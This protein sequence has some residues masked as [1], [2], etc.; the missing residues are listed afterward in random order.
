[1][2]ASTTIDECRRLA[3][4]ALASPTAEDARAVVRQG[5]PMLEELG[6]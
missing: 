4:L 5:L 2:L 6:L 1:V 3:Q